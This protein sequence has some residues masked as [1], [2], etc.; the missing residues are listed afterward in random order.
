MKVEFLL[1]V[2]LW[3]YVSSKPLRSKVMVLFSGLDAR[4]DSVVKFF[5]TSIVPVS[6]VIAA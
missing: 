5:V 3:A 4:R 6:P 2:R 1:T